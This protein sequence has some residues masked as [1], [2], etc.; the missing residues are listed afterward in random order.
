MALRIRLPAIVAA[1][2][3]LA[4][5]APLDLAPRAP[6]PGPAP[7]VTMAPFGPT[8]PF[9]PQASNARIARDFLELSFR[10]ESGRV[11]PRFTRYEGPVTLALTGPAP[12]TARPDLDRLLARLR[13]EAGIDIAAGAAP[14]SAGLVVEFLPRSRMQ[15]LVPQAACFVVPGVGSWAEYRSFRRSSRVDWGELDERRRATIFIPSDTVPQ[16]VRDCLHE[17]IAQALG[18]LNDLYRLPD[19]VF[20]DDN[21]HTVLTGFDMLILRATYD[22]A[23]AS[24]MSEAEVAQRLP[25]ILARLN[26]AGGSTGLAP[27]DPTPRA[28]AEAI[29]AAFGPRGTKPARLAAAREAVGIA[30]ANGWVD[31][32]AGFAW[33]ALGRLGLADSLDEAVR[34]F[35]RARDIYRS[36]PGMEVQA[37][38]VEMQLAAFALSTDRADEALLL[39]DRAAPVVRRAENAAL[40]ATLELIRAE[41]LDA[42]GQADAA[43]AARL[44][45]MRWAG[46]GFGSEAEVRRRAEEI[47]G[48]VPGGGEDT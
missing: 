29:E 13:A 1:G 6:T 4:G 15:R 33:F 9:P 48:L 42:L 34:A 47:A 8:R 10:M 31:T 18:P 23:L 16:E 46:Y 25:G 22:P 43:R 41:A 27:P 30:Q 3:A 36:R 35:F 11:L 37:A 14:Q 40:L 44:D 12:P 20:N 28:F 5:C 19:S 39:A 7:E 38:H 24:G 21:F 32:R 2:L 26:P 45:A 17:E